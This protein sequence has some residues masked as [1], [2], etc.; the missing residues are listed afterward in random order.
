MNVRSSHRFVVEVFGEAGDLIAREW[1][2]PDWIP[3]VEWSHLK[4]IREHGLPL[5]AIPK[6][7]RVAPQWDRDRGAPYV[8]SLDLSFPGVA[9]EDSVAATVPLRY[10]RP[11]IQVRINALIEAGTLAE[12]RKFGSRVCAFQ[13]PDASVWASGR[14]VIGIEP[15]AAP[16]AVHPQSL[17]V[18]AAHAPRYGQGPHAEEDMP[19]FIHARV[20]EEAA[21]AACTAGSLE[22][23]GILL[24][25]FLRDP[26]DATLYLEVTAQIPAKHA[27]AEEAS[28][29]FTAET[30]AAV[31]AAIALRGGREQI[32]GWHHSHPAHLWPCRN[33]PAERRRVCQANTPFFSIMDCAVHRTAFQSA[34]NVALLLSFQ[35]SSEP[36]IDLFGWREG[37]VAARGFYLLADA[38]ASPIRAARAS[39]S[40]TDHAVPFVEVT[41][42]R[43]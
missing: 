16:I 23:G 6:P 14:D 33:C 34:F 18:L 12:G 8:A 21:A 29:R 41:H 15:I 39:A 22:A 1:L 43:N 28:L 19:V 3:A 5:E 9:P 24:G 42:G 25:R 4:R 37:M 32:V 38:A 30:W 27:L 2:Q 13:A 17:G 26:D 36:L 35:E 20:L 7:A 10:L 11:A 40:S 31:Q